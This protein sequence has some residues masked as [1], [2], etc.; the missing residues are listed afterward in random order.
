MPAK[1]GFGLDEEPSPIRTAQ[2]STQPGEQGSIAGPQ[3][4]SCN[5]ATKYRHLVAEHYDL[6]RQLVTVTSGE[7]EQLEDSD[8]R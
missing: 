6:Y 7:A 5:L 1:Q 4:R 2:E 8:E 3:C